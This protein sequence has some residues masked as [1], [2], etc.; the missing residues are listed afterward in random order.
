MESSWWGQQRVTLS[1]GLVGLCCFRVTVPGTSL[2]PQGMGFPPCL[3]S[4]RAAFFGL[5]F[6]P[7]QLCCVCPTLAAIRETASLIRLGCPR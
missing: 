2:T 5:L 7:E 1:L 6:E 3:A 4:P